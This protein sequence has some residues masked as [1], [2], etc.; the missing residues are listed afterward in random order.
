MGLV[1]WI[2][3]KFYSGYS[4]NWDDEIL[5]SRIVAVTEKTD[6][7]LDLGAGA[8]L[9]TQMNFRGAV[10]KV[11]GIDVDPRILS[12]KM[13]DE[14]MVADATNI[15][16]PDCSF[17]VVYSDNVVEHLEE[18]EKVFIVPNEMKVF[19]SLANNSCLSPAKTYLLLLR[20]LES[21]GITFPVFAPVAPHNFLYFNFPFSSNPLRGRKP[22][23]SVDS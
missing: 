15:P 12:N 21:T 14:G 9:V 23:L 22:I 3:D 6:V 19:P 16:Y 10:K 20:K 4:K 7:I 5:R 11:C 13:I 2:D 8:G 17:D 1:K 18:P